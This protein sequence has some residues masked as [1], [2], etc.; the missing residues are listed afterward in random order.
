MSS[1]LEKLLFS[2]S[3]IDKASGPAGKIASQIDQLNQRATAGF[4]QVGVGAA[5]LFATGYALKSVLGP[6][7]EMDRAI[8]EVKSL[9]VA[10]AALQKLEKTALRFSVKYGESATEFVR[11]SYDIQSAI[12]GLNG[13]ELSTFTETGGILA[14]ATKSNVATI[15]DY[16]GTMYGIFEKDA[17]RMGNANWV[18]R[19]AEQTAT[20]V[21]AF[22]TDGNKMASA[23]ST[24][25]ADATAA[26]I[27]MTEQ[28]AV[29]GS[30]QATMS[31]SESGTKY[32]AFLK[33]VGKAQD[34]L[35]LKF[36][37][38]QGRM[39]PMLDILE[40]LQGRYGGGELTVAQGDE[41]KKAFGTQEAVGLI[42]QLLPKTDELRSKIDLIGNVQGMSNATQMAQKMVDPWQQMGASA[43]AVHTQ[44]GRMIQ[45]VLLPVLE[46]MV[47]AGE[48]VMAWMDNHKTLSKVI[49]VGTLVIFGLV[50]AVSAF[51]MVQGLA[52]LAMAGWN[53]ALLVSAAGARIWRFTLVAAQATWFLFQMA[54]YGGVA[55]FSALRSA[56][57]ASTAATWL[58]NAALLANPI[59]WIV[60]AVVALVA[61]VVGLIVYW[62]ELMAWFSNTTPL[63]L[64]GKSLDWL[65]DK[66][67]MIPGVN[68]G[69]GGEVK[70][71]E[72]IEQER[73]AMHQASAGI[74][75]SRPG[76]VPSGGL[77]QQVNQATTNNRGTHVEAINVHTTGSVSGYQLADELAMAGG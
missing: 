53:G 57:M 9:G 24:L 76:A 25:G 49:A 58:F 74:S 71:T 68:I 3:L 36:T 72:K 7:I 59:T 8:G 50:A 20:A 62:D 41:L 40:K 32:R 18:Q 13:S 10:D 51:A 66:L 17:T 45:P 37:D 54:V 77:L 26:G 27:S 39:L 6:A 60:L 61:A 44:F 69:G 70:I 12:S 67:N 23:F 38:S 14:K 21:A 30:L 29:L 48:A 31:G 65:I 34:E 33:G 43:S 75:Q 47:A 28:M 5:G 73:E 42:N 2:V 16:M 22:K 15:T 52:S 11:A 56:F 4:T 19:L 35:G 64:L 63:K 46:M 1:R 55:I